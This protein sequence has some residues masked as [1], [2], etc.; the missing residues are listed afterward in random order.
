MPVRAEVSSVNAELELLEL[1]T[2]KASVGSGHANSE[3]VHGAF[4]AGGLWLPATYPQAQAGGS[5][6]VRCARNRRD[7]ECSFE[8]LR[9]TSPEGVSQA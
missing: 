2:L 7:I 4:K 6:R 8:V 1:A 5:R 9:G 3:G